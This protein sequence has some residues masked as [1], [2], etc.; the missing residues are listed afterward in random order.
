MHHVYPVNRLPMP[1]VQIKIPDQL[2]IPFGGPKWSIE[3]IS[4]V[5][6]STTGTYLQSDT[7][8]AYIDKSKQR[9]LR[10]RDFKDVMPGAWPDI[11]DADE[12]LTFIHQHLRE[13]CEVG[14]DSERRFLDLYFDYCRDQVR[15]PS[16]LTGQ[17]K[18]WRVPYNRPEWVFEALLPLPQAHV[19]QANPL[20]DGYSFFP[21][22]MMKVD[23]AF[24]TGKRLVAIEI[25]GGSHIG[26]EAHVEKDRLLQRA[27][28]HTVHILNSE[29]AKYGEKVVSR[30]LPH[31]VTEFWHCAKDTW[32]TNPFDDIPF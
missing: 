24:W 9:A 10:L 17:R 16:Y 23:F 2:L 21:S 5:G 29:V 14:T 1:S 11:Y 15:P 25:D 30:L 20:E 6:V 18:D 13:K 22:R 12:A 27:G 32:P 3:R 8:L 4:V 26:S 28:V 7:P 31:E 19:Y